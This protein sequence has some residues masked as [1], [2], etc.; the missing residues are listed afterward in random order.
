MT[1][2]FSAGNRTRIRQLQSTALLLVLLGAIP[3]IVGV[4]VFGDHFIKWWTR[5]DL[6]V[7]WPLLFVCAVEA[8]VFGG[9]AL[10]SLLPLAIN[11]IRTLSLVYILVNLGALL[12]GAMLLRRFDLAALVWAFSFAGIAYCITGLILGGRLGGFTLRGLWMPREVITSIAFWR[13][14]KA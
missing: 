11:R 7:T 1:R 2:A 6:G 8:V 3:F 9:G 10:C 14:G 12:A 13:V 5:K 4:T